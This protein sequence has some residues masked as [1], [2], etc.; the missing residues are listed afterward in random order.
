MPNHEEH[1][2]ESLRR[3]GTTFSELHKWM[4][5]P[6][7]ILGPKHRKY[8]HDPNTTP[9]VAR[10]LFGENADHAC[11]DH[12]R[13]DELEIRRK[14]SKSQMTVNVSIGRAEQPQVSNSIRFGFFSLVSFVIALLLVY[15]HVAWW[16]ALPFFIITFFLFLAFLGSLSPPKSVE[17]IKK[18]NEE[19]G[20][21]DE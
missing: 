6:S 4:D 16:M 12:I 17:D 19:N 5:E 10:K 2:E 15:Q 11:L 14:G 1:C 3:Y 9:L 21:Q 20:N 7:S 18:T 13:L 8:R